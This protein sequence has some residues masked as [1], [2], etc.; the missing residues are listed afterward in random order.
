MNDNTV[1]YRLPKMKQSKRHD[2]PSQAGTRSAL[3]STEN[4]GI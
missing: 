4:S 2:L 3:C 1:H